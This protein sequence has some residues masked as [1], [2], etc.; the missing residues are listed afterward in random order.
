MVLQLIT[1]FIYN[2]VES[3]WTVSTILIKY[4]LI[5]AIIY[6]LKDRENFVEKLENFILETSRETVSII[7]GIGLIL[8]LTSITVNPLLKEVSSLIALIYFGFL[9]WKF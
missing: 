7:L 9:F 5:A 6:C 8:T 4:F 1:S 3:S 2:L